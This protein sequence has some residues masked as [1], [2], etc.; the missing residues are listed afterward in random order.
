MN[1]VYLGNPLEKTKD[2]FEPY[3]CRRFGQCLTSGE[4]T[5]YPVCSG[6]KEKL[7]LGDKG[8]ADKWIDCLRVVDRKKRETDALQGLL[9]GGSAFLV[10]GGPSADESKMEQLSHRG[11]WSLAVN[12]KAGHSRY[13]G[14]AFVCSDPPSKFSHS[15]WLDKA[16]MKFVPT[17]KMGGS[18]ATLR[19]KIDGEF[20]K[21]DQRV[22]DCPNV[23][24]FQRN[25]WFIPDD[26]FFLSD[27][28]CWGNHNDG[29]MRTGEPKTV[30]TMLIAIRLLRYLGARRIFLVGVDFYMTPDYGY[31]FNQE[32]D[33]K[34][35][36]SNTSQFRVV[37]GWLCKMQE[38][39]VF[40]RFGLEIYN[41]NQLSGLRA[42]PYVPFADAMLDSA[43]LVEEIPDLADWYK[44]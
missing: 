11:C 29:V 13:R 1:C 22:T 33:Q 24:G 18:R 7:E 4:S 20:S 36:E 14:Q 39:R 17:V 8:F 12:N 15:I 5:K 3:Q 41:T 30:C 43:G 26:Q 19:K 25:S 37:N 35:C 21:L 31:S 23:W 2:G 9:A 38:S 32:R 44:K 42:F 16:V 10:A 27:G 40:A 6:C 34:A 28:A